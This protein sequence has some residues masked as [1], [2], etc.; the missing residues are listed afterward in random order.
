MAVGSHVE[1]TVTADDARSPYTFFGSARNP[2]LPVPLACGG[3]V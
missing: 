3:G 1:A 2:P